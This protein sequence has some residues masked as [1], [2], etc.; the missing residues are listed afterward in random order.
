MDLCVASYLRVWKKNGLLMYFKFTN[1]RFIFQFQLAWSYFHLFIWACIPFVDL[2]KVSFI[3]ISNILGLILLP[4]ALFYYLGLF[5]G[6]GLSVFPYTCVLTSNTILKFVCEFLVE[7]GCLS[8]SISS[9][10][11]FNQI[12]HKYFDSL[13]SWLF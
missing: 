5:F 8:L 9:F 2:L 12:I 1:V 13:D 4:F 7:S 10:F 3:E 11:F 6:F